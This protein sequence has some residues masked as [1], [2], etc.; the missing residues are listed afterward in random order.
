ML[1]NF[2]IIQVWI[3]PLE[4][5]IKKPSAVVNN[6]KI[7]FKS[8]RDVKLGCAASFLIKSSFFFRLCFVVFSAIEN[9]RSLYSA[10]LSGKLFS[11]RRCLFILC[12][13]FVFQE[14]SFSYVRDFV[15]LNC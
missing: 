10:K 8:S 14:L 4:N 13:A 11:V 12:L 3:L 1:V 6:F 5:E 2:N 15:I 9:F 7:L